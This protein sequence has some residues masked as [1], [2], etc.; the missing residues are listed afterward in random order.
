MARE[1]AD[2]VLSR[3]DQRLVA[4]LQCDGR[5]TAERA[6][7]V[8]GLGAAAV[9][10]RLRA[11]I[12]DGT[13]RVVVSPV[14]RPRR[15]GSAGA[16]FLRIRVLRGR[17]DPIVAAL[18]AREDIPFIDVTTAGDEIFAVARTEPGSRDRL[19]FRQLPAT[20]AVESWESATILHVFR[21]TSEWRHQVLAP[22]ERAALTPPEPEPAS[23]HS[24]GP[25]GIEADALE[26]CVLDALAPDARMP[27]AALAARC[28]HPESTVRR[29]LARMAAE[30]R[31]VT[32]VV[33]DP[34]R[35][36]LPIEAKFLLRVA[37]DHLDAAGRALAAHPAVHG[38]F[39]TSGPSNLHAAAYFPDLEALYGFLSRDL[40]GLGIT[41]VETAV[42]GHAAK[43]TPGPTPLL[44]GA[45]PR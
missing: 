31:L 9:R 13:V 5:V 45:L 32:Q 38:A 30:G 37:P 24:P 4:A 12:A 34:R 22:V 16:L 20:S 44:D 11:L 35:L 1:A 26:Q 29:R 6:A 2:S 21:L 14:A 40:T 8:L 7:G 43:R 17:L 36:G 18:A 15:G 33:V 25:Y 23:A 39:A 42:V 3:T 27:A 10:R 28:G 41:H 19:V